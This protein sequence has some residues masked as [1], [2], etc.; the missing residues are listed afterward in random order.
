MA[1]T[2]ARKRG[3]PRRDSSAQSASGIANQVRNDLNSIIGVCETCH[4]PLHSVAPIAEKIGVSA[5]VL[6]GFIKGQKGLSLET[7][8]RVYGWVQEYKANPVPL[9]GDEAAT[10][11]E[12]A[13][14]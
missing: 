7:F 10:T 4:R 3:R 12:V 13:T 14:A 2:K 5:V 9:N 11:E 1:N 8:D 6:A